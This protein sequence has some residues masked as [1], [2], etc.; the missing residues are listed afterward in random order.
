MGEGGAGG[1]NCIRSDR[2]RLLQTVE[3]VLIAFG[4]FQPIAILIIALRHRYTI[5]YTII[6]FN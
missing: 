5:R 4:H 3:W 2:Q 6:V 1:D